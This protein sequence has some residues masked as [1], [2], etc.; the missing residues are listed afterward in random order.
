MNNDRKVSPEVSVLYIVLIIDK[1]QVKLLKLN[2]YEPFSLT[3][4]SATG[5]E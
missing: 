5:N 2:F 3:V 1:L 4:A